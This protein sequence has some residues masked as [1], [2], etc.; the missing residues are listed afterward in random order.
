MSESFKPL[1]DNLIANEQPIL[2]EATKTAGRQLSPVLAPID[3]KIDIPLLQEQTRGWLAAA[4]LVGLGITLVGI[5][6]YIFSL[7]EEASIKREL[8]TL[9]WTSEMTLVSSALGFYFGSKGN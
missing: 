9:V 5:G 7:Q 6:V 8:I 4:L 1:T 3:K 2:A